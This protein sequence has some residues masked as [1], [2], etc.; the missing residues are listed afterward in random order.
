[1]GRASENRAL[2]LLL[3][4]T[5]SDIEAVTYLPSAITLILVGVVRR[6]VLKIVGIAFDA[7]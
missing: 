7:L 3:T 4:P 2:C 5:K 6:A 1:M